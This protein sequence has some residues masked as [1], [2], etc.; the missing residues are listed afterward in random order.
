M[1]QETERN[2]FNKWL[3]IK[4]CGAAHDLALADWQ[5]SAITRAAAQIGKS[6]P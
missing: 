6:M 1:T 5:A 3:G 2:K 4:H